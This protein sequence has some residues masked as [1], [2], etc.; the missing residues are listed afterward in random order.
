MVWVVMN[1]D[2]YFRASCGSSIG[3]PSIP[4]INHSL[5]N[6]SDKLSNYRAPTNDTGLVNGLRIAR[7]VELLIS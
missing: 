1:H 2:V 6:A 4:Y 5:A 3:L 7:I